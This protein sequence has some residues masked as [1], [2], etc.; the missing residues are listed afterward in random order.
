MEEA[1]DGSDDAQGL[2][3]HET[4]LRVRAGIAIVCAIGCLDQRYRR[5]IVCLIKDVD[6]AS[7]MLKTRE[8]ASFGRV[9]RESAYYHDRRDANSMENVIKII[10]TRYLMI[11]YLHVFH[12]EDSIYDFVESCLPARGSINPRGEPRAL[13][14]TRLDRRPM[15]GR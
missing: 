13:W 2:R 7:A 1:G 11:V 3:V 6:A 4:R 10:I 14:S 9:V 15:H 12:H 5:N 8:R